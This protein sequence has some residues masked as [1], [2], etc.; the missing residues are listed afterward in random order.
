MMWAIYSNGTPF[1][2]GEDLKD[3]TKTCADLNSALSFKF[4]IKE[5]IGND[6]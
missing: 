1:V 5:W 2:V 6:E 3:L 4:T